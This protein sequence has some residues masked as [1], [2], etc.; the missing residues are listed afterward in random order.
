VWEAAPTTHSTLQLEHGLLIFMLFVAKLERWI[1]TWVRN[2]QMIKKK[3]TDK[4]MQGM[5]EQNR[6]TGRKR[7]HSLEKYEAMQITR[8]KKQEEHVL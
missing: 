5:L 1:C 2:F 8:P 4:D 7:Q 3:S 6:S